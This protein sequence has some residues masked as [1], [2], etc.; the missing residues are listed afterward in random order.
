MGF[1]VRIVILAVLR[2]E[3]TEIPKERGLNFLGPRKN[4]FSAA[5]TARS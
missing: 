4:S 3:S 5:A 2:I 1:L